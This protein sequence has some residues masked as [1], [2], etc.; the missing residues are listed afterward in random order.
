MKKEKGIFTLGILVISML[1]STAALG[2]SFALYTN[3]EETTS[4]GSS[5]EVSLR[6]YYDSGFGTS[7][8]PFIITR[9]RH[10]YNLSRL[11]GLGVYDDP[12]N[13]TYFQLGKEIS[14]DVFKCYPNDY[15]S[16][17]AK[18][19]PY[20]DMS[21]SDYKNNPVFSI[22]SEALPFYG[23]FEGNNLEIKNLTVY[24]D[25][26]DVG[27]FGYTAHG[28]EIKNLFLTDIT[29]NALG[30]TSEY[31]N[32]YSPETH[33]HE[34]VDFE[35]DGHDANR[36]YCSECKKSYDESELYINN[37]VKYCPEHTNVQVVSGDKTYF[38]HDTGGST[39]ASFY[40]TTKYYCEKC[41][42]SYDKSSL[43]INN[44][45]KYCPN[46]HSVVVKERYE[47]DTSKTNSPVP[48]IK[49]E[50]PKQGNYSQYTYYPILSGDLITFDAT[51]NTKE[52]IVPNLQQVLQ[53]FYNKIA[54]G[55]NQ[56]LQ[57][58][59]TASIVAVAVDNDG[60]KH[61]AVTHNILIK[62]TLDE[63]NKKLLM[64]TQVGA[65]HGN[66]IGIIVGHCDGT[67]TDCYV[68]GATLNI[69]N[70][71]EATGAK[72]GTYKKLEYSSKLGLVGLIGNTVYNKVSGGGI[73]QGTST[74]VLDFSTI[75]KQ[76]INK[77]SFTGVSTY[78]DGVNSGYANA[79]T[80]KPTASSKYLEY[81]R[82]VNG[83]YVTL[84]SNAVSFKGN[85]IISNTDL[86]VFTVATLYNN[87]ASGGDSN[88]KMEIGA[89]KHEDDLAISYT[90]GNGDS[91]QD[92]FV[93]YATGEYNKDSGLS[94]ADYQESMNIY[95]SNTLLTGYHLPEKTQVSKDLMS[96]REKTQNYFFRFKL[97][98]SY[99]KDN[100]FYFSDVD[101]ESDGGAFLF[102][103]FLYKLV[104]EEGNPFTTK[105]AEVGVML[106]D[107]LSQEIT[108]FSSSYATQDLSDKEL[109]V[110][111]TEQYYCPVCQKSY[112][113]SK[114]HYS[115]GHYYCPTHQTTEVTFLSSEQWYH[116]PDC[117][118]NYLKSELYNEECCP[119]DHETT[120]TRLKDK[121]I[122]NTVN[123]DIKT[124][125]ANVTVVAAPNEQ[126][127]PAALGVYKI[128]NDEFTGDNWDRYYDD[129]DYAFF[130]PND[131]HLAYF[132]YDVDTTNKVGK[133]GVYD[134][135]G[136]FTIASTNASGKKTSATIANQ[137]GV[138]AS[139]YAAG[140][141]NGVKKPR[142]F[143]HTFKL[144]K[145]R[146]CLGS[147]SGSTA[148]GNV[149]E[150]TQT[151]AKIY[152]VC[153]QGQTAGQ[154]GF[155][156]NVFGDDTVDKIDFVKVPRF[157]KET[158]IENITVNS[159]VT[160]YT[161]TSKAL[162]DQRLYVSL[163]NSKPSS[164][165][166]E[167]KATVT[168]SY[169]SNSNTFV[170]ATDNL[171]AMLLVAVS[172]YNHSLQGPPKSL[173]VSLF[174]STT[175]GESIEK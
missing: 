163:T 107:Y 140:Y 104:D 174:G 73:G 22:G 67:A 64:E 72:S 95:N 169:T 38:S 85:E 6:S 2:I 54:S 20:L 148:N 60:Q 136:N 158:K 25:P 133:I 168:F 29:I 110:N 42:A 135:N 36:W 61:A 111:A 147:A 63:D 175:T 167:H 92:Y 53:F 56:S 129:P 15:E 70:G 49:I 4:Q 77:N 76:I 130:M 155:T 83:N 13:P 59:S 58:S 126:G 164:F 28:S 132:D 127:K 52:T 30:Y 144:P 71:D 152:Y 122:C 113:K 81:L 128:D 165:S 142:L 17:E 46:H 14:K 33:I 19:V 162:E 117:G 50:Y 118:K 11:Q 51:D 79:T 156:D 57:A 108:G 109:I 35:Y 98:P 160:T 116:C 146:Y 166:G 90:D 43:F 143:A 91:Q 115:N 34:Y 1:L 161:G 114:L 121:Y 27:L 68:C 84:E 26:Q 159:G 45:V 32:L 151:S 137:G 150:N 10:L 149:E 12:N 65:D 93:Y 106:K 124:K 173:T 87:E 120:P 99:R 131:N 5:G 139:E 157:D 123:F 103:Y 97:E 141:S 112:I 23:V 105:R 69:N 41:E 119:I 170:I 31:N 44:E 66:N 89:I 88:F 3:S 96:E 154:I 145:G 86:G 125:F 94:Y 7:D 102:N 138:N 8:K 75:H 55:E 100:G 74:G 18:M 24:A 82:Y 80:Y 47:V 101:T 37:G 16:D 172:N 9:P 62:F 134:A 48:T 21:G 153:A 39:T 78:S 171:S 40:Y